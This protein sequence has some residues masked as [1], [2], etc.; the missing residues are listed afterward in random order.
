M[1][2][3]FNPTIPAQSPEVRRFSTQVVEF[4]NRPERNEFSVSIPVPD[5]NPSLALWSGTYAHTPP[6]RCGWSP[7]YGRFVLRR[8]RG[9]CASDKDKAA[10]GFPGATV[11][12]LVVEATRENVVGSF[13]TFDY[14]VDA[15]VS[16]TISGPKDL[17]RAL[18]KGCVLAVEVTY[19]NYPPIVLSDA[20][21]IFD[22]GVV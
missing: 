14:S 13:S 6:R 5:A 8:V 18:P 10:A 1:I 17:D 20:V 12:A 16:A 21:I 4:L 2:P 9:A 7:G 22:I 11:R 15:G 3:P 19:Q